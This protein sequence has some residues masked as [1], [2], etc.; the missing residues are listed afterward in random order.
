MS[1]VP[2]SAQVQ[3]EVSTGK[4]DP[5]LYIPTDINGDGVTDIIECA[6]EKFH[7]FIFDKY[8]KQFYLYKSIKPGQDKR[9][10]ALSANV[11]TKDGYSTEFVSIEMSSVPAM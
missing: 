4:E 11:Q 3:T 8:T 5:Y 7:I 1:A 2:V 6:D 10:T 9:H